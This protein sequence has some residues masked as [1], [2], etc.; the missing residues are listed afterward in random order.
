MLIIVLLV[1]G[2]SRCSLGLVG[3]TRAAISGHSRTDLYHEGIF[4]GIVYLYVITMLVFI[5]SCG[6]DRRGEAMPGG[7][8]ESLAR[9]QLS[10]VIKAMA[11]QWNF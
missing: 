8:Y 6:E 10:H 5:F 7:T 1:L 11:R 4:S 9:L 3:T 2:Y